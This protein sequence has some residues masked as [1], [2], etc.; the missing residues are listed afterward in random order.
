MIV[1]MLCS[2]PLFA[3][4]KGDNK[5][6]L[7]QKKTRLEDEIK[8]ANVILNDMRENRKESISSIEAL[9][10]KLRIREQLLRTMRREIELLEIEQREQDKRILELEELL[11]QQQEMYARMIQ[12]AYTAR[13][14]QAILMFILSSNDFYQAVKRVQYLRQI[15]QARE[16]Q[17]DRI[18]QTREEL[19][20]ERTELKRKKEEKARLMARQQEEQRTLEAEK[21][22]QEKRVADFKG[23]EQEILVD[24][25]KKQ[26][27]RDQLNAEIQRLIALEIQRA[28]EEAQRK[29]IEK[30]AAQV[31]LVKGKDFTG[32]TTN[33]QLQE[34]IK[35]KREEI[36]RLQQQQQQQG[37][38]VTPTPSAPLEELPVLSAENQLLA[39]NFSANRKKLPWPVERGLVVGRFGKHSH[40]VATQVVIDNKGIDIATSSGSKAKAVFDGEVISILRIPG[41]NKA[42]LVRHGNYF[43]VY[44]NLTD[45][46]VERG[47]QV[48]RG[49]NLGLIFT[50][51]ENGKTILHFEVW[52]NTTVLDPSSWLQ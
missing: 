25:K 19:E 2:A 15:A 46:Y 7:Q 43:T 24:I 34:L 33:K 5:E 28:K 44:S 13:D 37:A 27:Q 12:K 52:Q 41:A 49:Q 1:F 20:H 39:A 16:K 47:E 18:R 31:G 11:N 14:K 40:A 21:I 17:I 51:E 30:E 32:K 22:D 36:A 23:R 48:K 38:P 10:Q 50:D 4:R 3:Q 26:Q 8:L 6:Q 29:Q 42:V 45:I 35:K 9:Q